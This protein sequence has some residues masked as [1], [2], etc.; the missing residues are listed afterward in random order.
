MQRWVQQEVKGRSAGSNSLLSSCVSSGLFA[1]FLA[2]GPWALRLQRLLPA[3]GGK[4]VLPVRGIG[5]GWFWSD[6]IAGWEVAL[7]VSNVRRLLG[8]PSWWERL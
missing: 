2:A 3:A 8:W 1:S 6:L 5:A 4:E 7:L